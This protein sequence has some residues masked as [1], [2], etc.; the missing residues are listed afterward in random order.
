MKISPRHPIPADSQG[1]A[2]P[3]AIFALLVVAL[4]VVGGFY[5][6]SQ[7]QRIGQSSER[8]A[9]ARLLAEDGLNSFLALRTDEAF[10]EAMS[11]M[12]AW[13]EPAS[14][15]SEQGQGE[16]VVDLQRLADRTYRIESTGRVTRGGRLAGAERVLTTVTRNVAPSFDVDVT[17]IPADAALETRGAVDVR[18]NAQIIG[19]D[20]APNQWGGI[21][22][23]AC[24][25]YEL[26]NRPGVI[27]T[28]GSSVDT[29]GAGT[30]VGSPDDYVLQ[31]DVADPDDFMDFGDTSWDDLVAVAQAQN[32]SVPGGTFPN[33]GP[34][35][36]ENDVCDT[37]NPYNWGE[38]HRQADR[39][40]DGVPYQYAESDCWHYFPIIHIQGNAQMGGGGQSG[41]RGQ[42]ILLVDGNLNMNGGFEFYGLI[43]VKGTIETQGNGNR[44][45]GSVRAQNEANLESSDYAGGSILQ[46]SSCAVS[47]AQDN[48]YQPPSSIQLVPVGSRMWVDRTAGGQ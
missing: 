37:S 46:Y 3:A 35:Y 43:L 36:T 30:I 5:L 40:L 1:F 2:L 33:V 16:W 34:S 41:G 6:S 14:F 4:L 31:P 32:K 21:G 27:T 39:E 22:G 19:L 12:E 10:L 7:E 29:G 9:E 38:P 11:E 20:S 42:G 48:V 26:S 15:R 17:D 47:R 8:T 44:I 45:I 23:E 24:E 25:G 28:Q 18:G 13:G